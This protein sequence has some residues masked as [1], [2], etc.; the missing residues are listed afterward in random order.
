MV[1]RS[2]DVSEALGEIFQMT[3]EEIEAE[4]DPCFYHDKTRLKDEVGRELERLTAKHIF[5]VTNADGKTVLDLCCG[6]GI[7]SIYIAS[8]G[9]KQVVAVDHMTQDIEVAQKVASYVKPPLANFQAAAEDVLKLP[10]E[11]ASFDV[12]TCRDAISHI[13][14]PYDALKEMHRVLKNGGMLY[15]QD[16]NSAL[17]IRDHS[18]RRALWKRCEYGPLPEEGLRRNAKSI[19]VSDSSADTEYALT[20]NQCRVKAS[21]VPFFNMRKKMIKHKFPALAV[22][23]IE[24]L[25]EE[26]KGMWGEQ[27]YTAVESYSNNGTVGTK[28]PYICRNPVMGEVNEGE[29]NPFEIRGKMKVPGYTA[30]V[31]KPYCYP[32]LRSARKPRLRE[33]VHYLGAHTIRALYPATVFVV[34]VFEIVAQKR[35]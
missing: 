9:A 35:R 30:S 26:T 17:N 7:F 25:A 21:S 22:A 3:R 13:R 20:E 1:D 23:T 5:D 34:P 6:V 33:I 16:G 19:Y 11:N 10:Y 8:L 15:L 12:V 31:I 24:F 27:I 32:L 4:F 2:R 29:F 14:E 28:P 18:Q